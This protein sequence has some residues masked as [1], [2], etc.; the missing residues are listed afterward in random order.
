[1]TVWAK[2]N[3]ICH[4][5]F[6]SVR[7]Q[8]TVMNLQIRR[9]IGRAHERCGPSATF[10]DAASAFQNLRNNVSVADEYA[11]PHL[12]SGRQGVCRSSRRFLS[13]AVLCIETASLL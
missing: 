2:P 13:E 12:N 3:G 11:G 4:R 8:N 7:Q 6:T 10:A 9:A 5:V 1:M